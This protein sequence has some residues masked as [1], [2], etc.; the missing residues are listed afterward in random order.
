M[1]CRL[2]PVRYRYTQYLPRCLP[3]SVSRTAELLGWDLLECQHAFHFDCESVTTDV[4][5][6]SEFIILIT[7]VPPQLMTVAIPCCS[8][9]VGWCS[10]VA[11]PCSSTVV[12]WCS[13][14]AIPFSSTVLACWSSTAGKRSP[15]VV[16]SLPMVIWT[17]RWG[18]LNACAVTIVCNADSTSM[19]PL[20]ALASVFPLRMCTILLW[21]HTT[22]RSS[23]LP[24]PDLIIAYPS[25]I[26]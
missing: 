15:A 2:Y 13:F 4:S 7:Y 20:T 10:F 16:N 3:P 19:C 17:S 14:L 12:G 5:L 21:P 6:L 25:L 8:T 11:I 9:V 26:Q 23:P 22:A 18:T 24:D 1:F